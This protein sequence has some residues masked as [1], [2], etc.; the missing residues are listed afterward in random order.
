M[1]PPFHDSKSA[2]KSLVHLAVLPPS[3]LL[4]VKPIISPQ[5]LPPYGSCLYVPTLQNT[6]PFF[7]LM[8]HIYS[9][10]RSCSPILMLP[11]L[12]PLINTSL[13]YLLFI[14]HSSIH[15]C[16]VPSFV[17]IF[18]LTF[19]LLPNILQCIFVLY[20]FLILPFLHYPMLFIIFSYSS[21]SFFFIST[22]LTSFILL[23]FTSLPSYI[24]PILPSSDLYSSPLSSLP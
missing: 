4:L 13:W 9:L 24:C 2:H 21:P 14:S 22:S 10:S 7:L 6:S 15:F 18:S 8:T 16:S 23:P 20:S 5:F 19:L 11:S 17:C 3:L 1:I 12:S